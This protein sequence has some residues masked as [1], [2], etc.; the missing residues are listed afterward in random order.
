[1]HCRSAEEYLAFCKAFVTELAKAAKSPAYSNCLYNEK[2]GERENPYTTAYFTTL[3]DV[4]L[5]RCMTRNWETA[6]D[7]LLEKRSSQDGDLND[8]SSGKGKPTKRDPKDEDS[9]MS[10]PK[11][12]GPNEGG[13]KGSPKKDY[14]KESSCKEDPS[15][16]S[17]SKDSARTMMPS[18]TSPT[19]EPI[20]P[21][22]VTQVSPTSSRQAQVPMKGGKVVAKHQVPV[23]GGPSSKK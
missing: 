13:S 1:M 19:S 7:E 12:S 4:L 22:P 10:G 9:K 8:D 23:R 5:S 2:L 6:S 18:R 21:K 3:V 14:P 11:E 20:S 16:K 15:K 17:I